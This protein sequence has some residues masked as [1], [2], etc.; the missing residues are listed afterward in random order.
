[1]TTI[2]N[3]CPECGLRL[4]GDTCPCGWHA[5][6]PEESCDGCKKETADKKKAERYRTG[7]FCIKRCARC[8]DHSREA[9][10]FHPNDPE[11]DPQDRGVR[12]CPACWIPAL[13]RRAEGSTRDTRCPEPDCS[14]TVAEHIA[15]AKAI[16]SS[17][18]WEERFGGE[19]PRES[20]NGRAGVVA[21]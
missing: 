19:A 13:A 12:L 9:S 17:Q 5:T 8:G 7:F 20:Q 21:L 16:T 2:G 10:A 11:A 18:A 15:E 14:K 3:D 4:Q 1:M 6:A